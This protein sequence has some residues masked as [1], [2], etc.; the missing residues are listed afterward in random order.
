MSWFGALK[1][2]TSSQPKVSPRTAKR[3]KLDADRKVRAEQRA[4]RRKQLEAT[5]KAEK[6]ADEALVDLLELDPN[7]FDNEDKVIVDDSEVSDLLALE[8]IN[9]QETPEEECLGIG[10]CAPQHLWMTI[11]L[12]L[13]H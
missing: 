9:N 11:V 5:L 12:I 8:P 6:E 7:I 13:L 1:Q 10:D 2:S 4:A 3:N